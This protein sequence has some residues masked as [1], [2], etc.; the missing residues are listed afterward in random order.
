MKMLFNTPEM[1]ITR[2]DV[3][4]VV[5][6]SGNPYVETSTYESAQSA[7]ATAITK[8]DVQEAAAKIIS[9]NY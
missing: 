4:D 2:F 1:A 6:T 3:A 9:F 5:T 8:G 7:I